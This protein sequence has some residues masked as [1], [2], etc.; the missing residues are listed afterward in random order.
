M[1][2]RVFVVGSLHLDVMVNAPCLPRRDET[3]MGQAVAY[4]FGGKGGNQALAAARMGAA[5]ALAGRIGQDGFGDQIIATLDASTVDATQVVRDNGATGMSV[6]IVEATG[7]YGAVVVS[8]ANQRIDPSDIH[9]PDSARVLVLQNEI[10]AAV[11]LDIAA[12]ARAARMRVIWNA[13]PAQPDQAGLLPLCDVL[14]VN[15]V[16]AGDMTGLTEPS[17]QAQALLGLGPGT[18]IVTLGA[19]GALLAQRGHDPQRF[20]AHKVDVISTHGAGDMFVGAL[21]AQLAH[22]AALPEAIAFAQSAAARHVATPVDQRG[23]ITPADLPTFQT[24]NR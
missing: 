22:D 12:R 7:D 4:A 23:Q 20:E 14:I 8:A 5:T 15:R 21:A 6:A 2:A 1:S 19:E 3:L 10:R 17:D 18:V 9:L 13:A 11:N 24:D 16:E